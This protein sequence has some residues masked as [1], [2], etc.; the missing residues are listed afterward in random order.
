MAHEESRFTQDLGTGDFILFMS[1][2]EAMVSKVSG[3]ASALT[4]NAAGDWSQTLPASSE[5]IFA[6]ELTHSN[7]IRSGFQQSFGEQFGGAAGPL[8]AQPGPPPF[9]GASQL[10]PRTAPIPKGIQVNAITL[11]Y[12]IATADLTS[13]T[14]SIDS[15]LYKNAT[16][17]AVTNILASG[18]NGLSVTHAATDYVTSITGIPTTFSGVYLITPLTKWTIEFDVT[19]AASSVY[20]LCGLYLNVTVNF[21]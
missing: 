20:E 2:G 4:R 13:Q 7:F 1:P 9:K 10:T 8:A 21:L 18:A 16:A 12:N 6:F 11:V 17:R 14:C 15:V 3:T 5:S 19:T